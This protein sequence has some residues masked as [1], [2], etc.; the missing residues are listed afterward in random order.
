M[1]FFKAIFIFSAFLIFSSCSSLSRIANL[2]I[3]HPDNPVIIIPGIMGS[4]LVDS[5]TGDVVW[6]KVIDLKAVNPHEALIHPEIDGL[7]LPTDQW[8]I[9]ENR[10]RLV[11]TN[12]LTKYEMINRVAEVEAYQGLIQRFSQCGLQ[13][14]DIH[15]CTARDNLYLFG[16]DWRRDLVETARI[17]GERIEE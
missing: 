3:I 1:K 14:G 13:E 9:T 5:E 15:Q 6:G 16:Y 12:I 2:P 8:P 4:Q 10:D 7:E 17:L 11:P